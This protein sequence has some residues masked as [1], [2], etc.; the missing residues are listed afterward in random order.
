MKRLPL[1]AVKGN[2]KIAAV[3]LCVVF[4]L[5]GA[6]FLGE[7]TFP[8]DRFQQLLHPFLLD[9][10]RTTDPEIV[11]NNSVLWFCSQRPKLWYTIKGP[12]DRGMLCPAERNTTE[13][14]LVKATLQEKSAYLSGHKILPMVLRYGPLVHLS[15]TRLPEEL[16]KNDRHLM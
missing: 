4:F 1:W 2:M 15:L 5:W 7:L 9:F 16:K 14:G 11:F 12:A 10:Q 13:T 8:T 6:A 3:H